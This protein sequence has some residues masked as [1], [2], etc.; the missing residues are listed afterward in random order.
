MAHQ[1]ML[2]IFHE[3]HKNPP[4]CPPTYFPIVKKT[5]TRCLEDVF[6]SQAR[7]LTKTPCRCPKDVLN[8]NLENIFVRH[9]KETFTRY[10][11]DVL[12]KTS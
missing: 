9:I 7:Y 8:A 10:I 2:K 6:S 11:V 4:A 5:S 3:P 12:Q 1:Y